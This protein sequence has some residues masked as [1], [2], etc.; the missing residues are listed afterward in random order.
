MRRNLSRFVFVA[1]VTLA[2]VTAFAG[3]RFLIT[4][5]AFA[6]V[7]QGFAGTCRSVNLTGPGDIALDRQT[8]TAF[9]AASDRR[10]LQAGRPSPA[11][12]LYS[13]DYG[14]PDARPVRL[15]GMPKD[16]HP[17]AVALHRDRG[18]LTLFV[19][20]RLAS[21]DSVVDVFAAIVRDGVPALEETGRI[22]SGL[23]ASPDA[24]AAVDGARF[25]VANR[26]GAKTD[27]GRRFDDALGLPRANVLFFD[28]T[29]FRVAAKG[30]AS[31]AGVAVSPDG[32]Y[33]YVTEGY[34]RRLIAFLR[35]PMAG[36]LKEEGRLALSANPAGA[37]FDAAGNLWIAGSPKALA[38]G[39]FRA[40]Q[41]RPASS[42]VYRVSLEDGLPQ[43]YE[44]VYADR[45]AAIGA[46]A[47]AAAD[48]KRL[49]V[50]SALDGKFLDCTMP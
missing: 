1:A 29:T 34:S 23:L 13:Y 2:A 8:K 24:V 41:N 15:A 11:D 21:G 50:G 44:Q 3:L 42:V 22:A 48:G 26:Y 27:L 37:A 30:L 33:L 35:D 14:K 4:H 12:G 28:G 19:V 9:I 31:P 38:V 49:F 10:A 18:G 6:A 36:K 46:A 47:A 5:G 40:D 16:F 43:G 39:T 7:P 32:K 20:N 25:Y 17:Q 45:G